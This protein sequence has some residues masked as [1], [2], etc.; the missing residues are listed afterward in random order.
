MFAIA[1]FDSP[2]VR[3]EGKAI[4]LRPPRASDYGEWAEL[5]RASRKFLEPWEPKWG[6]SE[7]GRDAWRQ[8]MRQCRSD[9]RNGTGQI[10]FI[11]ERHSAKLAGGISLMNIRRG[12]SQSAQIGY[13]MGERY[14]GRGYMLEA[15]ALVQEYCFNRL[16]LHRI[17]AA[18]IPENT[19]SA[20][21]LEKA[22]FRREGL[23]RSYL[24]I[25]GIWQDHVLYA[26][27]ADE[28]RNTK[29]SGH[30]D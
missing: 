23:M 8:R 25:N 16:K 17:E 2:G 20:H 26:V 3:I 18:C 5:R 24:R 9:A 6:P 13:W 7:L 10:F 22:G 30:G 29:K 28:Y 4:Y 27:I 11:I 14:A 21:V 19:R 1:L 12:V 15:I